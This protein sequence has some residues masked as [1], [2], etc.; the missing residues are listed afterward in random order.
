MLLPT[1]IQ[2]LSGRPDTCTHSFLPKINP[3]CPISWWSE[4]KSLSCVQIFATPW[5]VAYQAP[6]PW[7]FPGKSTGVGC[8][9]LLQFP[10]G[11]VVNKERKKKKSACQ[12]R[13]GFNPLIPRS[14]SAREGNGNL[15]QYSCLGKRSSSWTEEPGG[16]QSMEFA[17]SQAWFSD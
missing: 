8:H 13:W 15:L 1:I 7:N 5:T 2:H 4:V 11:S 6:R 12:C 10:G 3:R 16:L 9:F 17:E 14:R